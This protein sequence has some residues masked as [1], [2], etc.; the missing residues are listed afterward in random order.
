MRNRLNFAMLITRSVCTDRNYFPI[1]LY[2]T[3][4]QFQK[5]LLEP[6]LQQD[7][8]KYHPIALL[9]FPRSL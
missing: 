4:T 2:L 7:R 5:D 8:L 3:E 6:L 9:N 1:R